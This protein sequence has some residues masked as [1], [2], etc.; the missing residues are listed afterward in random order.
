M[1]IWKYS[2][3]NEYVEAQLSG[4][5]QKYKTHSYVSKSIIKQI[6]SYIIQ[7]DLKPSFGLCHGTRRG[8]E[9]KF[10]KEFFNEQGLDV[11]VLGTEI[12][13]TANLFENTIQWDFNEVK[14]EWVGGVDFIYSNSFDHSFNPDITIERWM[15][16]LTES[17]LC[18]IEWGDDNLKNRPMDP[19]AG[20][21]EEW[22]DFFKQNYQVVTVIKGT[23][24]T[25][26]DGAYERSV[27]VLKTK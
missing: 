1:K 3:Y 14:P 6:V 27:I 21:L 19:V 25:N 16:C 20:T 26:S 24:D 5:L 10:F 2:N 13:H 4:N 7:L 23:K 9:Q 18:F 12:S 8:N 17:G 22:I 11:N 15:S